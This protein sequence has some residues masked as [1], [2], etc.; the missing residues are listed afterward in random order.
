MSFNRI[1]KLFVSI[2]LSMAASASIAGPIVWDVSPL[3]HGVVSGNNWTNMLGGQ[4]FADKVLFNKNTVIT[5]MDIYMAD[6]WAKLNDKATVTIYKNKANAP[7]ALL[8]SFVSFAS[9]IDKQG[10]STGNKRVH[11][12]FA[13]FTMLAGEAYWIGMSANTV[14]WTQTSVKNAAGGNNSM[15]QFG[16]SNYSHMATVGDMAFRLH[17]ANAIPEPASLALFGL[18]LLGFAAARRRK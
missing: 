8:Q 5:G 15:A 17:G 12:D 10:A 1:S 16:G 18:G 9:V 4:H 11:V 2:L 6:E 14:T 3:T 7:G 13:G